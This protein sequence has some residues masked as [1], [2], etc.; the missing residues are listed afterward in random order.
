MDLSYWQ[1]RTGSAWTYVQSD[2][3]LQSPSFIINICQRIPIQS[4][5]NYWNLYTGNCYQFKLCRIQC[6]KCWLAA[7]FPS[8]TLFFSHSIGLV[9]WVTYGINVVC[10]RSQC[11][12]GSV[13]VVWWR[14]ENTATDVMNEEAHCVKVC[15][16]NCMT[17]SVLC[18]QYWCHTGRLIIYKDAFASIFQ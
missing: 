18:K 3:T 14:V 1:C 2:L 9:F 8:P 6:G 12:H 5:L 10:E 7:I 16:S 17:N 4:H 11:G 13:F 15:R